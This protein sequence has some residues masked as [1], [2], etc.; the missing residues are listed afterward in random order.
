MDLRWRIGRSVIDHGPPKLQADF[1]QAFAV[2]LKA[3]QNTKVVGN[4]I[5]TEPG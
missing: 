3:R 5:A 2:I 4:E 1:P